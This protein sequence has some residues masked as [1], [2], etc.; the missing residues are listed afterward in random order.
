MNKL[1]SLQ[2]ISAALHLSI[3]LYG[4]I[5][6]FISQSGEKWENSAKISSDYAAIA[7]I[8]LA[9]SFLN[10]S[11][12]LLWPKIFKIEPQSDLPTSPSNLTHSDLFF[13]F[14]RLTSDMQSSTIIRMA[15]AE[16]IAL[17]GFVLCILH[18]SL[19]F[20]FPFGFL[21]LMLQISLGALRKNVFGF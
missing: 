4:L 6:F 5:L 13:N 21:A 20:Y 15:L 16:S 18:H 14:D 17:F 3:L 2:I 12:A 9:L 7:F 11:L 8:L 10:A 1:K 19:V